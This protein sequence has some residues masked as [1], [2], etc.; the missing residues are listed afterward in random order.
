MSD[1]GFGSAWVNDDNLALLTDLYELRM[2]QSYWHSGM[3]ERAVFSLYFR[4]LPRERNFIL[5]C[6]QHEV[7]RAIENLRF[8]AAD[9]DA[10]RRV[11]GFRDD[12]LDWL[13]DFRFS[14][15]VFA[16]PEG[17]PLFPNEP[18][19]EVEAP[20]AE[21]QL[22]ES[23]LMNQVHLQTVLASKAVRFALAARGRTVVDFGMRRMHGTDAAMRGVRSYWIAGLNGTSN[24]LGGI[25]YDVPVVGTMAHSYI[26]AHDD[27]TRAFVDF[28]ELYPGTTL[29]VD[30]YDSLEGVRR[31]IRLSK[32]LGEDFS[33]GGVRLDSGDHGRLAR[34]S[35][36]LLDEAGMQHVKILASGGLDEHRIAELVEE[37]AP[38]DGFGV[39]TSLGAATDSPVIDLAYKL[40]EYAGEG[41]TKLSPGKEILP[42]RKQIYRSYRDGVIDHDTVTARDESAEGEPLLRPVMRDGQMI[43]PTLLLDIHRARSYAEKALQTLPEDV[44]RL[45]PA[46]RG[47]EVRISERLRQAA[48]TAEK[49]K[50]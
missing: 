46:E 20:I 18:L 50:G 31:V 42:G 19:M 29:L 1:S 10:L 28:A 22:L 12:F 2:L 35:R 44:R 47:V 11:G 14:G 21:A 23:I 17:T 7:L 45:Q 34:E 6:G 15:D 49:W 9:L 36:H 16:V 26:Q 32:E 3:R 4:E 37:D 48:K 13:G 33:V 25:V 8:S 41:R 38:I 39:G 43:E 30:T 24:V 27:E 5:A 40:T